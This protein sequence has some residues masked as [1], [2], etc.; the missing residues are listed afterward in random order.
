MDDNMASKGSTDR[1]KIGG[2]DKAVCFLRMLQTCAYDMETHF[3]VRCLRVVRC[4]KLV[5]VM[6]NALHERLEKANCKHQRLVLF[7]FFIELMAGA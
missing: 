7:C 1:W 2:T 4:C 3:C 6:E 5:E